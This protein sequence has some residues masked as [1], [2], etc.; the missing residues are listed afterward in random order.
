MLLKTGESRLQPSV[1]QALGDGFLSHPGSG[2]SDNV[3]PFCSRRF[4]G[5]FTDG[6]HAFENLNDF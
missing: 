6:P 3:R 1:Y 4:C 2:G 5:K